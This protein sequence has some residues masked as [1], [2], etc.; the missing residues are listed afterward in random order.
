MNNKLTPDDSIYINPESTWI[1]PGVKTLE[2]LKDWILVSLGAP[3]VTVELDDNQLNYCIARATEVYTKY[4]YLGPDKFLVVDMNQYE[5]EKGIN[6]QGFNIASV[7]DIALPRDN[8]FN[9]GGDMFWGAYAFLGQGNGLY[10][11]FNK[12][13]T[14][15]TIGNWVTW[16]MVSEFFDLT[17]RMTGSNPDWRYDKTTQYI[18]LM[19]EPRHHARNNVLLLTCQVVPPLEDLYG[20][21]YVKRIALAHAKILLGTI[22]RKFS[23][24]PLLGGAQ[25]DTELANEGR[26][27][28]KDIMDNIINQESKGQ[29]CYIV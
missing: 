26:E 23:N 2:D 14:T 22:R 7:K 9:T 8:A 11:M 18:T 29:S 20:N 10:P 15:P 21:E 1:N 16:H 12:A 19:P 17:K 24:V 13:G 4:A 5:H 28:L 25:V 3:R 6:L 27:E